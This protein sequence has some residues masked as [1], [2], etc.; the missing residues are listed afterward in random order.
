MQKSVITLKG[1]RDVWIDFVTKVKKS[2]SKIW[3]VLEPMLKKYIQKNG[4]NQI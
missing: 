1:D 3:S 2:K 4:K